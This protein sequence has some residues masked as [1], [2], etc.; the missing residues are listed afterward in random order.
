M[1]T[2][3][4]AA[5]YAVSGSARASTLRSAPAVATSPQHEFIV[6]LAERIQAQTESGVNGLRIQLRPAHLGRLEISAEPGVAGVVARIVT[7][8]T[9]VKQYLEGN[10]HV[11]EQALHDQGLRVDRLDVI[12]QPFDPRQSAGQQ[13]QAGSWSE[14]RTGTSHPD[15]SAGPSGEI[16]VDPSVLGVLGP[17]STFHTVA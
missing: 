12:A 11:L 15:V 10:L 3:V 16:A 2:T 17:N 1:Q 5:G 8:S 4:L 7:E 14:R 9:A 6:Q 13:H